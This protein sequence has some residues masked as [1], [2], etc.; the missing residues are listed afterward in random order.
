MPLIKPSSTGPFPLQAAQVVTT[1]IFSP[2]PTVESGRHSS[3]SVPVPAIVGGVIGG[4][5]L[6]IVV[7]LIWLFWG[8]QIQKTKRKQ[9]EEKVY[10]CLLNL[11]YRRLLIILPPA[12]KA[13]QD[14][15]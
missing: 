3:S 6:A 8:R 2:S 13:P 11:V 1:T 14:E 5:V 4:V 9:E 10:V 15:V 7:T 12:G